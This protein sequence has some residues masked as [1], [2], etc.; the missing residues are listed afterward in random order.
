M[1]CVY[2]IFDFNRISAFLF[3]SKWP[4]LQLSLVHRRF[5]ALGTR[6]GFTV[7][8]YLYVYY[9]LS[10]IT[11]I[12]F[13]H[14]IRHSRIYRENRD[15]LVAEQLLRSLSWT[16]SFA[17]CCFWIPLTNHCQRLL[18]QTL[19]PELVPSKACTHS[20]AVSGVVQILKRST[21]Q[22]FYNNKSQLS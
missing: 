2:H 7:L 13:C 15:T 8:S 21:N 22:H 5:S 12:W 10:V 9:D 6:I 4:T 16:T 14:S 20:P 19:I 1:N 17:T 3:S 18:T 11:F